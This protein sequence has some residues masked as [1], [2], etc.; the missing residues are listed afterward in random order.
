[1]ARIRSIK[2]A[3]WTD[4][5]IHEL[6]DTTALFF[7][8][9]WNFA[10]DDGFFPTSPTAL[11]LSMPRFTQSAIT[12]MLKS[13]HT[14]GLVK[15][16]SLHSVGMVA[17]WHHQK[18]DKPK[19][20]KWKDMEIQWDEI[21]NSSNEPRK[22]ATDRRKERIGED[23]IGEDRII[24]EPPS[25]PVPAVPK[26]KASEFIAAYCRKFQER[27]GISPP[28]QGKDQ[29]HAKQHAKKFTLEQWDQILDA[30]FHMPDAQLVKWKHP[31]SMIS[32]KMNEI[33]VY[34]KSGKFTSQREARQADD[35]VAA[36][37]LIDSIRKDG[38]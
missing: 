20:G 36:H 18:I 6:S 27:W 2:P 35:T 10:D 25:A 5:K 29:G 16:C 38:I 22:V 4:E 24:A 13:L 37:N 3:F 14:A 8:G 28:I 17:S 21:S 34:A 23:R 19:H 12:R 9:I 7:I 32:V 11:H 30:Y 1:M 33:V 31:L 26:P 15:L